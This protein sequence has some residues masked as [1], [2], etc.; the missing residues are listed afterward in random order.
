MKWNR[1]FLSLDL[2]RLSL[3]FKTQWSCYLET[4]VAKYRMKT[5]LMEIM[6]NNP[7][8]IFGKVY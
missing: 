6:E 1:Q 5:A 7:D 8:N 3:Q 2:R 4:T